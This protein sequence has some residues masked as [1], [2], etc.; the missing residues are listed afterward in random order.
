M[1]RGGRGRKAV[2]LC[3]SAYVWCVCA[4]CW[5][6]RRWGGGVCGRREQERR[7]GGVTGGGGGSE[8]WSGGRRQVEVEGGIVALAG[9]LFP[10]TQG[11]LFT[12]S[13][14]LLFTVHFSPRLFFTRDPS[15][16]VE[17]Q[18]LNM[19]T[20]VQFP[21]GRGGREKWWQGRVVAVYSTEVMQ[22]G[23]N[24]REWSHDAT[25]PPRSRAVEA[26]SGLDGR[27]S[28]FEELESCVGLG[29]DLDSLASRM[30][31]DL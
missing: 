10:T 24:L 13:E 2:C 11:T 16:M 20:S 17:Q 27:S 6:W 31:N 3:M 30:R 12:T 22:A 9:T 5:E 25:L 23:W 28:L 4:C 21:R 8:G 14:K 18:P 1:K 7:G 29:V 19:N 26:R 15:S